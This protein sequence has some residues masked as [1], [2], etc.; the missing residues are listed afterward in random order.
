MKH[1]PDIAIVGILIWLGWNVLAYGSALEEAHLA[2]AQ[3]SSW[4]G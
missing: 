4:P 3:E 1:L 2:N